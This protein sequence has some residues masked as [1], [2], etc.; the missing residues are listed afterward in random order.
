MRI[1]LIRNS[2]SQVK[3]KLRQDI[4]TPSLSSKSEYSIETLCAALLYMLSYYTHSPDPRLASEIARHLAWL[5]EAAHSEGCKG[6]GETA[7]RLLALHWKNGQ[8][9]H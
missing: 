1:V 2:K 8:P 9:I 7:G 6:L 5:K 3:H 4:S